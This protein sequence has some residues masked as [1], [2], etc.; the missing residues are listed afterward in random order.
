MTARLRALRRR[1]AAWRRSTTL[2]F[3]VL[4]LFA[5]L[6]TAGGVLAF[7]WVT[8]DRL[9][10]SELQGVVHGDRE[11][12]VAAHARGGV[13]AVR[14][15]MA[16]RDF[17]R[18]RVYLLIDEHERQVVG[19]LATWPRALPSRDDWR[20]LPLRPATGGPKR[21]YG[22]AATRLADGGR[23]LVGHDLD[24]LV[25][26]QQRLEAALWLAA[27]LALP[28]ALGVAFLVTREMNARVAAIAGV[29]AQVAA[30][31]LSYRIATFGSRD[32]FDRL[33][34]ALNAMLARIE[35]L[36]TELRT[37]ADSLAHDLRSPL[38]RI[39][40]RAE[41]LL[42]R[43][44]DAE[45]QGLLVDLIGETEVLLKLLTATLEVSRAEAGVGRDRFEPVDLVALVTGLADVYG[46]VAEDDGVTLELAAPD[47]PQLL[48]GSQQLL[49]QALANLIENA[50]KYGGGG[51]RILLALVADG[52][53][54]R[55]SVADHGPGI[56]PDR[57]AEALR[58]FGRLDP[59]RSAPGTGLGLAL[60]A[61][62]ARLHGGALELGD[63]RP[64]LVATL[65]L[66]RA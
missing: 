25:R 66:P 37:L 50:L 14:D 64:G 59:A 23:L 30:G 16:E 12:L 15:E 17:G 29:A 46:P 42:T 7:A 8:T 44:P 39:R 34:A 22:L 11:A 62:V 56:P 55:L 43:T 18:H 13:R 49:A 24:D 41:R 32:P 26:L 61:A 45:N 10:V 65:V 9:L 27:L 63:N 35:M 2:R 53:M 51:G 54:V 38:G 19:N 21:S 47:S 5:S 3:I 52:P 57:R 36:M 33:G 4:H 40:G 20:V 6:A 31:D 48:P 58:R 60:V 1:L 28:L